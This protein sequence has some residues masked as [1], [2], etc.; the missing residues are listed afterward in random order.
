MRPITR[1]E[2]KWIRAAARRAALLVGPGVLLAGCAHLEKVLPART[3]IP[4]EC[5]EPIPE[6]PAMPT[7]NLT[8]ASPLDTSVQAMQAEIALREGYEGQLVTAL[9]ACVK[10]IG[11]PK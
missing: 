7:D 11:T 3:A 10:P 6:R 9:T 4:V 8:D 5:K 1:H 2:D